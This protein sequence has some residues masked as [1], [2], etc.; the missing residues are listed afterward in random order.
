M[1][2]QDFGNCKGQKNEITTDLTNLNRKTS[3]NSHRFWK[4][5]RMGFQKP[6]FLRYRIVTSNFSQK[7][8]QCLP[9]TL[10]RECSKVFREQ[11][12]YKVV[13]WY[14]QCDDYHFQEL[15]F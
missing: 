7:V 9:N 8:F 2:N 15:Y 4:L 14:R 12:K 13:K 10:Y 1:K 3:S 6:N 11:P 5:P